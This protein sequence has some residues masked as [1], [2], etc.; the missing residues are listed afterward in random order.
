MAAATC[1]RAFSI[2]FLA[3]RPK[4]WTLEALPY[5]SIIAGRTASA[6]SGRTRVVAALSR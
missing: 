5:V 6:T 3:S 1:A 2:A 4:E